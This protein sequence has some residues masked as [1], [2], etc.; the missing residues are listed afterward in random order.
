MFFLDIVDLHFVCSTVFRVVSGQTTCFFKGTVR[1][2]IPAAFD[3]NVRSRSTF[4][5]EPPVIAIR[6][7]EKVSSSFLQ[8]V[9]SNVHII[10]ITGNVM[11]WFAGQFNFFLRMFSADIAALHQFLF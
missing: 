11:H 8:V 1:K 9:L 2:F 5:M 4:C 10:T 6:L 7:K 3:D